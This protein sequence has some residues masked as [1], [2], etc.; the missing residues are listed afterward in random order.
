MLH[1]LSVFK[2]FITCN[3][4][5]NGAQYPLKNNTDLQKT[6]YECIEEILFFYLH[7]SGDALLLLPSF[8]RRINVVTFQGEIVQEAPVESISAL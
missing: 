3:E 7:V 1:I 8:K 2:E 5:N 6:F 4:H